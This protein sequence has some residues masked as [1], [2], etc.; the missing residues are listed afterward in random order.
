M[1]RPFPNH[2]HSPPRPMGCDGGYKRPGNI[3][4]N[5][6]TTNDQGVSGHLQK[7]NNNNTVICVHMSKEHR[8]GHQATERDGDNMNI[9]LSVSLIANDLI[10]PS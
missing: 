10:T 1:V 2:F 4:I 9:T 6:L 5:P 3:S 8:I 7:G